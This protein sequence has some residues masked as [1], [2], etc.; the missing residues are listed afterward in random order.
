LRGEVE[1]ALA[2]GSLAV[3]IDIDGLT[4]LDTPVLSLLISLLRTA[5]NSGA[6]IVLQARR[7]PILEA[8]NLTALDKI[9][10]IEA[11]QGAC[12]APQGACKAPETTSQAKPA[13]S[14]P[15][16]AGRLGRRVVAVLV[17]GL[18][19]L[20]AGSASAAPEPAP[21]E[22][23]ANI[24]A[25]NAQ[26][27]SY[28]AAVCVDVHLR[29]FPYLSQHLDGT[30]YFKRP[31]FYEVVFVSVPQYAKGFDKLYS[32]IGDPTDWSRRF[33]L[34]MSGEKEFEGHR[35]VVMRLVQKVRGMIDHEDVA[36]DPVAWRIDEME[37]HYYNGGVI[38]MSQEFQSVGGFTVLAK[39]HATIHIPFVHAAADATYDDYRTNVAIDDAVFTRDKQ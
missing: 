26:M 21:E 3:A 12:E 13:M 37:W 1:Q 29:S 20:L 39:Q 18:L 32:D 36:I 28:Q 16:R 9:F 5:R 23:V 27:R 24:V 15:P 11:P 34:T 31:D 6:S 4:E 7:T 25:Q 35:D 17:G 30:T 10:T 22:I 38:A 19:G 14:R 33:V 8:L 2:A